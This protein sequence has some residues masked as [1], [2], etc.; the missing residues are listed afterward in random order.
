MDHAHSSKATFSQAEAGL[1]SIDRD[2]TTSSPKRR[3]TEIL[4]ADWP[5]LDR[6][7]AAIVSHYAKGEMAIA[8]GLYGAA[9]ENVIRHLL[10]IDEAMTSPTEGKE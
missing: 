7:L 10:A 1:G 9:A 5:R 4:S 6:I 2:W 3:D 8:E